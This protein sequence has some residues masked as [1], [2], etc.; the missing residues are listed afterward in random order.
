MPPPYGAPDVSSRPLTAPV[1]AFAPAAAGLAAAAAVAL[2]TASV[3]LT[4]L[5][6][7]A[8]GLAVLLADPARTVGRAGT[9]ASGVAATLLLIAGPLL[10]ADGGTGREGNTGGAWA[11]GVAGIA[12]ALGVALATSLMARAPLVRRDDAATAAPLFA[13]LALGPLTAG[14]VMLGGG[15]T[16]AAGLVAAVAGLWSVAA[17]LDGVGGRPGRMPVA[18]ISRVALVAP[19]ALAPLLA[20]G[21][22]AAVAALVAALVLL[23]AVRLDE[24]NL[25][26][27]TGAALVVVTAALGVAAGLTVPAA[28]LV[29][30]ATGWA[31]LVVG[32]SLPRRHAAPALLNAVLAA[33]AGLVLCLGDDRL[34]A[35]DL[36]LVGASAAAVGALVARRDIV[37]GGAALAAGGLWIHLSVAGVTASEPYVLPV[38]AAALAWGLLARG[39]GRVS[40]WLAYT[41]PAVLLGGAALCERLAGGP[42]WHGFVAG[43][44]G[45]VAVILGGG[46][47]LVGPLLTGTALVL[48]VAVHETLGVTAQ[49]PTWLWLCTGGAGL[50]G[51]GVGMER[52]G[53]GPVDASRRVVD[54]IR[55]QYS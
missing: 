41:P 15:T 32:R 51:A 42:A 11:A 12:G 29:V 52:R 49:V 22:A 33:G 54:V 53:L 30:T 55:A 7:V 25:L 26:V 8:A 24:P 27:G 21:A 48:A 43:C 10:L 50:L 45:I 28:G 2:A 19:L 23:D 44:V 13:L 35:T 1:D 36:L 4:G 46:Y 14:A 9:R 37:V 16:L 17:V 18:T 20:P 6:S 38:A 5:A 47:R 40:S 3:P 31:W 34:L 39:E